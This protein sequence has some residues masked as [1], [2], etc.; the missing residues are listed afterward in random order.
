MM[1]N[2]P[3]HACCTSL[4]YILRK[5]LYTGY[6]TLHTFR[7]RAHEGNK[8]ESHEVGHCFTFSRFNPAKHLCIYSSSRQIV[9]E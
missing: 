1:H 9:I 3:G 4:V 2:K 7:C 8:A 5:E 6:Y